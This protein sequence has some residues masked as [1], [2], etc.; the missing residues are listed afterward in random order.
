MKIGV[1]S[2]SHGDV[3]AVARAFEMF[4]AFGCETVF[5]L[6]D[7]VRDVGSVS[8]QYAMEVISVHGNMDYAPGTPIEHIYTADGLRFFLSHGH[9]LEVHR[10]NYYL[11]NRARETGCQV[12]LYGHTHTAHNQEE[13]GILMLNPGSVSRPKGS[14]KASL[15]VI[16]TNGGKPLAKIYWLW[17]ENQDPGEA[18]PK[19][20]K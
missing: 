8:Q 15:A 19:A 11:R 5:H 6:G 18:M 7:G 10:T 13:D 14:A 17:E 4:Q 9:S 20:G 2:D 1:M 3:R 16:D 12:A